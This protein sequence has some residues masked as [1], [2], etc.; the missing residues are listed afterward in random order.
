MEQYSYQMDLGGVPL[1]LLCRFE[2]SGFSLFATDEEPVTTLSLPMEPENS[3]KEFLWF[4]AKCGSALLPRNR[5]VF[6]GAAFLWRGKAWILTAPPGTGKTTQFL[7]WNLLYGDEVTILNGDKPVLSENGD[8]SF[9]VCPTPWRGKE[10]LGSSLSAKLGG[11]IYLAQDRE[12]SI[13]RLSEQ[14]AVEPIFGQILFCAEGREDLDS[15][16]VMEEKLLRSVPVWFLKNRGDEA[17][18]ALCHETLQKYEEG[19]P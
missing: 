14:E 5:M 17:S 7:F 12:N 3:E 6:H 11:I 1:R 13:R 8:G 19:T 15:A 9:T 16:C 4:A 10:F 18:A 2:H